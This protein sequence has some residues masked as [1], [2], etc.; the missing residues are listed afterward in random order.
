M[1]NKVPKE[2]EAITPRPVISKPNPHHKDQNN[3]NQGNNLNN[4]SATSLNS[5]KKLEKPKCKEIGIV[6]HFI[7]TLGR[8]DLSRGR[9]KSFE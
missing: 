9:F 6:Y 3:S 1:G 7:I 5:D 2:K 4:S 8:Y